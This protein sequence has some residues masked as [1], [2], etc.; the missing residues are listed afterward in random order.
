VNGIFTSSQ[1]HVSIPYPCNTAHQKHR[2][3]EKVSTMSVYDIRNVHRNVHRNRAIDIIK[4][5]LIP[6]TI[7][8]HTTYVLLIPFTNYYA[9]DKLD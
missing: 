8:I 7:A 6:Q 1:I 5:A 3:L 9:I 4:Q 2:V